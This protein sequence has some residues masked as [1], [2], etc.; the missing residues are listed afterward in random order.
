M[1]VDLPEP[2]GP[3]TAANSPR[4]ERDGDAGERVDGG[5]ALAEAAGRS[6]AETI[7]VTG[8]TLGGRRAAGNGDDP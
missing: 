8:V 6:V 2:D 7:G 5:G 1:S 3:M 4:R